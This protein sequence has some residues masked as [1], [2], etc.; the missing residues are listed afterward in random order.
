[1]RQL[2]HHQRR[3][4]TVASRGIASLFLAALLLLPALSLQAQTAANPLWFIVEADTSWPALPAYATE[5]L[6]VEMP[7]ENLAVL[8]VGARFLAS[9]GDDA[10]HIVLLTH[11][12]PYINGD[13]VFQGRL[14]GDAQTGPFVLTVGVHGVFAYV[15]IGDLTW[16]LYANREEGASTYKGWIYQSSALPHERLDHDYVIPLRDN[17][18]VARPQPV[19]PVALPL[20]LESSATGQTTSQTTGQG[21]YPAR[22]SGINSG[23]FAIDQK[24]SSA[25]VVAGGSVDVTV[26]LRNISNEGHQDL[27]IN[28]YFVLENTS[29]L[30]ASNGCRQG[31]LAGQLVLNCPLG[32][33]APG[34]ARTLTYSVATGV[35]SKPNVV[36]TAMIGDL[37]HDAILKVVSDVQ[38]DSDGDGISD[39][40]EGLLAAGSPNALTLDGSNVVIDV[41][42][43][44]TQGAA[45]QYGGQAD[46]RINQ[47]IAV[48]NQIYADS[49]V[50][51]TLRPVYHGLVSYDDAV[52]MDKALEDLTYK[53]H[54]AF[55]DVNALRSAYGADLVMLFRPQG[56][57]TARCGLAN[58][59]GFNTQGDFLSSNEKDFAYSTIAIDCPVSSVVAH[60]LGHNMGLTHSRREDGFGGTFDFATGYGV[61]GLF[62]TVMAYPGAFNTD[63]R[64]A[65][66]SNPRQNCFGVPCGVD[67]SDHASGADAV[68]ALNLVRFQI[69]SYQPMQVPLLPTRS[70]RSITGSSTDARIALAASVNKGFEYVSA[71]STRDNIDVNVS[72]FVDSTHVGR[73][74]SMHVLATLD[75]ATFFQLDSQGGIH[76]LKDISVAG[77]V[78][79]NPPAALKAVEY[80][81]VINAARLGA[82][83]VNQRLQIFVAYSVPATGELIYTAEPLTLNI[84]P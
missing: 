65:R 46:T 40:N 55:G 2:F 59:G 23:N 52:G 51:I 48:A 6:A 78:P 19:A 17:R 66:F 38:T 54:P 39:F 60:E 63:V 56:Q 32:N 47:L 58:L 12:T 82:E 37:R 57:E 21:V 62:S 20:A 18:P 35:A 31:T 79:F 76:P 67:G 34:E 69:A 44:Y 43:L 25:S 4:N 64:V 36:S 75:G 81:R 14:P 3:S 24:F 41:M 70:V 29:L 22:T 77:L 5:A 71:V 74:G 26:N 61:D 28:F 13:R 84:M 73:Q 27:T 72:L 30:T 15:E 8:Q 10:G 49:G 42:A 11:E 68:R 1:M 53:K 83:F 45:S 7:V 33:F 80:V 16:Q 50:G 9:A